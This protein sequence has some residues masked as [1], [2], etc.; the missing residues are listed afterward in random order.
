MALVKKSTTSVLS[1]A[2]LMVMATAVIFFSSTA[3]DFCNPLDP[4]IQD[5]CF[6]FCLLKNY[7][8]NFQAYCTPNLV[9]NQAGCCCRVAGAG[10]A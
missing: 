1:F 3:A 9:H 8:G 10:R 2:V 6:E 7:K 5:A 4:C